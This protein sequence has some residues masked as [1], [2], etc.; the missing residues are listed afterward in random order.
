MQLIV[1]ICVIVVCGWS[2]PAVAANWP[3]WRGPNGDGV[4]VERELPTQWSSTKNV[5]WKTP[6][7]GEGNSVPIVWDD[8]IF[9]TCPIDGGKIRSL[10]CFDRNSGRKLWDVKIPY[11]AKE[12]TH[13]D[14][15]FCSGSATT[16]GRLVYASFGSAGVIA[17]DFDGCIVWHRQLGKLTHVF[18]QA[19]TPVLYN[20]LV[21]VHRGPGDPTHIVALDHKTG[22]TVWDRPERGKNDNLFGSW[23]TPVIVRVGNHDELIVS[24]PEEIKGFDPRTGTQLWRCGGLG[25]EVYTMPTVGK[26]LVVGISGHRGPAMGVRLGGKGDVTETHRLWLTPRNQQRVGCGIVHNGYLFVSN[27]T[28]IAECIDAQT[29][30]L[31]WRER[32]GGTLWGSMLLAGEKLYVG[33]QQGEIFVLDAAPQFRLIAKNVLGEHVKAAPAPSDGQIFIRTYQNLYCIGRR[34][35]QRSGTGTK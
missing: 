26:N 33:N 18:G 10:L 12:T 20:D 11:P 8:R 29:G 24:L 7:P 16:D 14:N 4:S 5:T 21:I 15:P 30:K 17:C 32:L 35:I 6:L 3:A 23:S 13:G 1:S 31:L 34:Q 25:T 22:S 28:G 27:A 9:V 19:T 2:V